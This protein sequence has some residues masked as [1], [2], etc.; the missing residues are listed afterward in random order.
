MAS[1]AQVDA[2]RV[3]AQH[4]TGPQTEEGKARSSR[5]ALKHGLNSREFFIAGD[6]HEE[7]AE[8]RDSLTEELRPETALERNL[9]S[10]V[11]H[12]AWS[13]HRVRR[14]ES[15]LLAT[16][17]DT[18]DGDDARRLELLGRYAARAE[19]S[20]HRNLNALRRHANTMF[21]R[22]TLPYQYREDASHLVEAAEVHRVVEART[23]AWQGYAPDIWYGPNDPPPPEP[24]FRFAPD[25]TPF[26][27]EDRQVL[28]NR[29]RA[30]CT[31]GRR[32]ARR[33]A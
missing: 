30:L 2:N 28:L 25:G 11:L 33:A 5:N 1:Q 22:A 12:A 24:D 31:I 3:N 14:M 18:L 27:D 17:P 26:S 32:P 21:Q 4:S 16:S 7:F 9:F 29:Y 10:H 6:E 20:Y 13:L 15:E 19:R 8:L 23:R